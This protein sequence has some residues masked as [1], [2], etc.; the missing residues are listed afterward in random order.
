MALSSVSALASVDPPILPPN[1]GAAGGLS[2]PDDAPKLN[3]APAVG[4]VSRAFLSAPPMEAPKAPN[5]GVSA[6]FGEAAFLLPVSIP[7]LKGA[8]WEANAAGAAAGCLSS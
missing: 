5:E 7:K 1:A 4:S 8:F 6:L 2:P 3:A